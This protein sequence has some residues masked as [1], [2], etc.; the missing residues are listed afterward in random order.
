MSADEQID[1]DMILI[2]SASTHGFTFPNSLVH[3]PPTDPIEL[4]ETLI[5]DSQLRF[6]L[7]TGSDVGQFPYNLAS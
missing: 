6:D 2:N 1:G 5:V 3:I 4:T 7:E